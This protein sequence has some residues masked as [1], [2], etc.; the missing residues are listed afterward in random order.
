MFESHVVLDLLYLQTISLASIMS[1]LNERGL[2]SMS[3]CDEGTYFIH[4]S[5]D[6]LF[7]AVE[8]DALIMYERNGL[9]IF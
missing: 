5:V 4:S 8:V 2:L 7:E 9:W 1:Y 3:T 6:L